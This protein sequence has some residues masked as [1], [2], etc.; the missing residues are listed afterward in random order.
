MRVEQYNRFNVVESR[1][2]S[3]VNSIYTQNLPYTTAFVGNSSFR[4]VDNLYGL[5]V[6]A[7]QSQGA[8]QDAPSFRYS[9][10]A[11]PNQ[12]E[13]KIYTVRS[14][15][16]SVAAGNFSYAS[17]QPFLPYTPSIH[18]PPNFVQTE[19]SVLG[20]QAPAVSYV[21]QQPQMSAT[22]TRAVVAPP[23]VEV[24]SSSNLSSHATETLTYPA[25][26]HLL[27]SIEPVQRDRSI[28]DISVQTEPTAVAPPPRPPVTRPPPPEPRKQELPPP[29]LAIFL[30]GVGQYRGQVLNGMFNGLGE[31]TNETGSLIF[32]GNFLDGNFE[33]QGELHNLTE[34]QPPLKKEKLYFDLEVSQ[35]YWTTYTGDFHQNQFHGVGK[36]KYGNGDEF[37][38]EFQDGKA[39]GL[40]VFTTRAGERVAGRWKFNKL[41]ERL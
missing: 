21:V 28:R 6:K 9:A 38:G 39:D 23:Q 13:A 25:A 10:Q 37:F 24:E 36:F 29:K 17:T 8:S 35:D 19:R 7:R 32:K 3:I 2:P 4:Q 18:Q 15:N 16:G 1:S 22:S 34:L 26:N 5:Q 31:L 12:P 11:V 30:P 40:G 41:V 27:S 14:Q 20:L 33:G